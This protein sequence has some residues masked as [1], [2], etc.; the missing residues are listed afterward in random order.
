MFERRICSFTKRPIASS[1]KSSV[2]ITL[3]DI[4]ENG[5]LLNTIS[6]YDVCGVVRRNGLSDG[7]LTDKIFGEEY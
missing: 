3:A 7:Y 4:D 6:T 2:Q 5:R 1:D